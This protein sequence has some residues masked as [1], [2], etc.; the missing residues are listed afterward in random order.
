[1]ERIFA[2]RTP[3]VA[4]RGCYIGAAL[5]LISGL[6]CSFLGLMGLRLFPQIADSRM[7]LPMLAL[8][9][10]PFLFGLLI[11]AGVIGAGASTANGGILGVSTV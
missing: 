8:S 11:L 9:A 3:Q 10:L 4:R 2:A 7:V 6:S 1:M 5:T